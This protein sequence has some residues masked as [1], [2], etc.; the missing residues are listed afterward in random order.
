L[1]RSSCRSSLSMLKQSSSAGLDVGEQAPT[2][3]ADDGA[4]A[5]DLRPGVAQV[6]RAH[7]SW[8]EVTCARARPGSHRSVKARRSMGGCRSAQAYAV[9]EEG[10]TG[11]LEQ[12]P[13][14]D[15]E[16]VGGGSQDGGVSLAAHVEAARRR[17]EWPA[18]PVCAEAWR[19]ARAARLHD[20]AGR[21]VAVR[22][23]GAAAPFP[24]NSSRRAAP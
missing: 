17:D 11:D 14:G 23:P 21:P 16:R 9:G 22:N 4:G 12:G 24:S 3:R 6:G 2:G 7:R 13:A 19:G 18:R 8:A 1:S 20:G 10:P 15:L 5:R